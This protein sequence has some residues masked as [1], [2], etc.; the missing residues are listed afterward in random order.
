MP[1]SPADRKAELVRHGRKITAIA[2][3]LG[4]S[5]S[6]VSL[7][8]SGHRRSPLIERAVADA[9][10]RPVDQVFPCRKEAA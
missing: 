9:I 2:R 3:E 7:V 10:S 4:V 8:V 5:I 6:H 1:M